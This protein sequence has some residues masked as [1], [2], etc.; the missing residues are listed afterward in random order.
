MADEHKYVRYMH[1]QWASHKLHPGPRQL[2]LCYQHLFQA[3]SLF[4]ANNYPVNTHTY[5]CTYPRTQACIYICACTLTH[6]HK[7][8]LHTQG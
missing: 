1:N 2:D 8:R 7:A 3:D 4:N 6:T 5:A